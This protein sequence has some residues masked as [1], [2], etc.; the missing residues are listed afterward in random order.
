LNF[1]DITPDEDLIDNFYG[2][3]S[4]LTPEFFGKDLK[5]YEEGYQDGYDDGYSQGTF[6][7]FSGEIID[8]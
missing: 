2:F 5:E 7:A 1:C 8:D 4:E 3:I 6:D